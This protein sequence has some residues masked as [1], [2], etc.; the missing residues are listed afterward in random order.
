MERL[1]EWLGRAVHEGRFALTSLRSSAG[2]TNELAEAFERA[3]D[4]YRL[5]HPMDVHLVVAG[6][7]QELHPIVRDEVYRIGYEAIRNAFTHSGGKRLDVELNYLNDLVLRIR[8]D[9]SGIPDGLTH[10]GKEGRFGI[11]GMRE[12]AGHIGARLTIQTSPRG[13]DVEL[14]VPRKNVLQRSATAS[15]SLSQKVRDVFRRFV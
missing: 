13:T 3:A 2:P 1:S 11:I 8:D 15:R 4:E 10:K 5:Q 7:A 9:G 14:R 12:R 6:T